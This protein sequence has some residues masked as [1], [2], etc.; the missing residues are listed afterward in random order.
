ME[1]TVDPAIHE[2]AIR[3]AV[4]NGSESLSQILIRNT[5]INYLNAIKLMTE[6]VPENGTDQQ[7]HP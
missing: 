6:F 5:Y 1:N 3:L 4:K 7:P 2:I